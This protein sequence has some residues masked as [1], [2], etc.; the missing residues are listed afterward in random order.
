MNLLRESFSIGFR[1]YPALITLM[2]LMST[3]TLVAQA[4][5][6]QDTTQQIELD[7]IWVTPITVTVTRTATDVFDSHAPVS[8]LDEWMIRDRAPNTVTDLFKD[9]PGLDVSGVGTNQTRPTIRGQRGQRILLLQDGMRLNNSRRQQDFG[10]IPALVDVAS[11]ESVEIVR[12]PASVLYGTDAIGGVV[13]VVTRVPTQEGLHGTV[14]YRF[15]SHDD[16]NK[17]AMS[18]SGRN[19][20]FSFLASGT[21]RDSD[22]YDAPSGSFG[23]IRLDSDTEVQNTGIQDDSFNLLLGFAPS[24]DQDLTFKLERYRADRTGFGFVDPAAFAPD[25]PLIEIIYPFQ[26]F[27]KYTLRYQTQGLN[28]AVADELDVVGYVQNNE[29]E[30]ELGLITGIGPGATLEVKTENFTD[31]ETAG[32]RAEAKKQA[33]ERHRLTY[34]LDFF[35]DDSKNTDLTTITILGFGPPMIEED[36]TSSVPNA[37]FRSV[38]GFLQDEITLPSDVSVVLGVRFQDVQAEAD[39]TPGLDTS[40]ESQSHQTVVASAGATVG[41]TENLNVIGSIGRAFRAPNLVELFFS[42]V[43]PEGAAFQARNPDLE[44]ETSVNVDVGARYRGRLFYVE[45][46]VFRNKVK[47]GIRIAQTGNTVNELPEFENVNVDELL[48][49]GVELAGDVQLLNGVYFGGNYT[50]LSTRDELDTSNPVGES[51]SSKLNLHVGIEDPGEQW[52]AEYRLRRNGD[53]EDVLL[54]TNPVGSELPAFTTHTLRG[55][56]TLFE[57]TSYRQR[58]GITIANLTDEL[59]AE[60]SN[61]AF[62]RP[63]PG[64]TLIVT[65]GL[66][67]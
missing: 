2:L 38:G 21:Y 40:L 9:L 53:R 56:L 35:R 17:G 62:F 31:L 7:L 1:R 44:P 28:T 50:Y 37:T 59:Y 3:G 30:L 51:F 34:G 4:D 46:F 29:R 23:D 25:D 49:R 39:P 27:D 18:L 12:G 16:Q 63:E 10:E 43:T 41:V 65:W 15:S 64:R 67:F 52:F 45:G 60:F 61:A 47:D 26:D 8:V 32:F 42:G 19:G 11:V 58:I 33:A 13:N 5:Q 66:D 6:A 22:P 57:N 48:F 24:P 14:G 20:R 36:D 54:I 55:G